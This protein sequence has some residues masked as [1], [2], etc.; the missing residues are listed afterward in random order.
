MIHSAIEN[1][2]ILLSLSTLSSLLSVSFST[3]G[4]EILHELGNFLLSPILH[5]H[6][7]VSDPVL[8]SS[9]SLSF[10]FSLC[11][12]FS[13]RHLFC[14]QLFSSPLT[15]LPPALLTLHLPSSPLFSFLS[16][17]IFSSHRFEEEERKRD[18]RKIRAS[19]FNQESETAPS[20]S[21]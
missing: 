21:R 7:R 12:S 10:S 1:S 11:L 16:L 19:V 14:T 5:I 15:P 4:K 9:L 18:R 13:V 2:R 17:T 6:I 3:H 20:L 8:F